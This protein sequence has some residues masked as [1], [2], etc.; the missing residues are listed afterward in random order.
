MSSLS[1]ILPYFASFGYTG[2]TL[3]SGSRRKGIDIESFVLGGD[4]SLASAESRFE[5]SSIFGER[6]AELI[7]H[8]ARDLVTN[9]FIGG[10]FI[11]PF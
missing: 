6:K 9:C 1:N 10:P 7:S 4:E 2:E 11:C 3:I 5:E 8:R